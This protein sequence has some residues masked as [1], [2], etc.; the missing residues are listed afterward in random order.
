MGAR[1]RQAG[2]DSAAITK[3][4]SRPHC[5][6]AGRNR[7]REVARGKD[8]GVGRNKERSREAGKGMT[9]SKED[10]RRERQ[11]EHAE[12]G[13]GE[14]NDSCRS[15]PH[16]LLKKQ[17]LTPPRRRRKC[18]TT[19]VLCKCST[20]M[21][22]SDYIIAYFGSTSTDMYGLIYEILFIITRK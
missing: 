20:W 11:G 5:R 14:G 17:L 9:G 1:G 12:S 21:L 15:P 10:R 4:A 13:E 7:E 16:R 8:R 6:Q 18:Y 3:P 22:N 19:G 2:R